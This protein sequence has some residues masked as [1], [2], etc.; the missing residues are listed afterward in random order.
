[1]ER[2]ENRQR[3]TKF[4]IEALKVVQAIRARFQSPNGNANEMARET[5]SDLNTLCNEAMPEKRHQRG[6]QRN[7]MYWWS[8]EIAELRKKCL[9]ARRNFIRSRGNQE[10]KQK[11]R[12]V[13]DP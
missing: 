9:A 13:K 10:L 1:M 6:N 7:P 12:E 8:E 2:K 5:N 3:Q 4:Q 11:L